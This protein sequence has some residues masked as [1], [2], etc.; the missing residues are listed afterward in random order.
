MSTE[1]ASSKN[2]ELTLYELHRKPQEPIT[3]GTVI[4]V[5][6]R[7]LKSELMCPICLDILK[8]T[9]T[10]KECLHR[11]CSECIITA[12]RS[13]N[14]E[15]PTCRKKLVSKRSLRRDPN[16]D[17]LIAKIYPSRQEYEAHQDKIL[18]RLNRQHLSSALTRSL[19]QQL[20]LNG[21]NSNSV[22]SGSRSRHMINT[23]RNQ[24]LTSHSNANNGGE[25]HTDAG[26]SEEDTPSNF[27]GNGACSTRR[28]STSQ[29]N[30]LANNS[31]TE[32]GMDTNSIGENSSV[33]DLPVVHYRNNLSGTSSMS[34]T[35]AGAVLDSNHP[36]TQYNCSVDR[37]NFQ[38]NTVSVN[39]ATN[40]NSSSILHNNNLSSSMLSPSV[41]PE[42][43]VLLKPHPRY[44]SQYAAATSAA[45]TS[46]T[47]CSPSTSTGH[48]NNNSNNNTNHNSYNNPNCNYSDQGNGL[49]KYLKAPTIT[50]VDHL[51]RYLTVRINL[52]RMN[53]EVSDE[54]V[55]FVLY[56][57]HESTNTYQLLDSHMSIEEISRDQFH[58]MNC[59]DL[60]YARD[61]L[62]DDNNQ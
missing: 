5:S 37:N 14:K 15:C 19:E 20:G 29:H 31:D 32:S 62:L 46:S 12:L 51:C 44:S 8:V 35:V 50:T 28:I 11:F 55:R 47:S 10:T 33:S 26:I 13:G 34:T 6:P 30:Q 61:D 25:V 23:G 22:G 43:E 3:D 39:A 36:P 48:R 56:S 24:T 60:Y 54:S 45:V 38:N 57:Y 40:N 16:F 42:I 49:I 18:A 53:R 17:A 52:Q 41:F 21:N 7:S 2:W 58:G 59:L 9:M 1:N 4:A 27:V